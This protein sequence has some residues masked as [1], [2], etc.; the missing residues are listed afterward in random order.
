MLHEWEY[1]HFIAVYTTLRRQYDESRS[2]NSS[3]RSR[4]RELEAEIEALKSAAAGIKK[5]SHYFKRIDGSSA[6]HRT[7]NGTSAW[8]GVRINPEKYEVVEL[9]EEP[10]D[11]CTKCCS[12]QARHATVTRERTTLRNEDWYRKI[13]PDANPLFDTYVY[14][15]R[16]ANENRY[17]VGKS[18]NIKERLSSIRHAAGVQLEIVHV[19]AAC[20]DSVARMAE[21]DVRFAFDN[22]R[23]A[24]E[25]YRLTPHEAKRVQQIVDE[26]ILKGRASTVRA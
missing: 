13:K 26:R 14:I 4:I 20:T 17:K 15:F 3:L 9:D 10:K 18:R 24:Q 22:H 5:S 23:L 11:I 16:A 19:T 12:S 1:E 2:E 6:S 8:C 7:I 21:N 25:W